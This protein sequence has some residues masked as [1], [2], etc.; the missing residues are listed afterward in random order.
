MI[1]VARDTVIVLFDMETA[2]TTS[3]TAANIFAQAIK[4]LAA[5][6][7]SLIVIFVSKGLLKIIAGVGAAMTT[8]AGGAVG[9]AGGVRIL[10]VAVRGLLGPFGLVLIAIEAVIFFWDDLVEALGF[11]TEAMEDATEAT[12]NLKAA[13]EGLANTEVTN[14][15]KLA[16]LQAEG[17]AVRE[18]IR[19]NQEQQEAIKKAQLK[20]GVAEGLTPIGQAF[21]ARVQEEE[22]ERLAAEAA[23]LGQE[24]TELQNR[25]EAAGRSTDLATKSFENMNTA[26]RKLGG[27]GEVERLRTAISSIVDTALPGAKAAR[28]FS[29]NLAELNN[30]LRIINENPDIPLSEFEAALGRTKAEI[31]EARDAMIALHEANKVTFAGSLEAIRLE[32]E[33]AKLSSDERRIAVALAKEEKRL[34]EALILLNAEEKQQLE[35]ALRL[36]EVTKKATTERENEQ[37]RIVRA[38]RSFIKGQKEQALG[39][40]KEALLINKTGREGEKLAAVFETIEKAT[41]AGFN[42]EQITKYADETKRAFEEMQALEQ[43]AR[44]GGFGDGIKD[45]F[46]EMSEDVKTFREL[47]KESALAM[48]GAFVNAFKEFAETGRI[49]L[50]TLV[51]D[52]NTALLDIF[53]EQAVNEVGAIFGGLFG[54]DEATTEQKFATAVET[55]REAVNKFAGGGG[56]GGSSGPNGREGVPTPGETPFEE[57]GFFDEFLTGLST[58][59]DDVI[60][61]FSADLPDIFTSAWDALSGIF[62]SESGGGI[63]GSLASLFGFGGPTLGSPNPQGG[64]GSGSLISTGLQLASLAFAKK[65][66]L[67]P[68]GLE[69]QS[70]ARGGRVAASD[71]DLSS[72]MDLGQG[73][74]PIIAHENESVIPA[75]E[76]RQLMAAGLMDRE[77]RLTFQ[78]FQ[79]GG[80]INAANPAEQAAPRDRGRARQASNPEFDMSEGPVSVVV[81]VNGATDADS[82]LSSGDQIAVELGAALQRVRARRG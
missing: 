4:L 27:E 25:I 81:E 24:F 21:T 13:Q 18:Q 47:V 39:F 58:T 71:L 77:G 6:V 60:N 73:A 57:P 8:A 69:I 78:A 28:E 17:D 12:N 22:L 44:E 59:F 5:A 54:D 15:S 31:I 68:S 16:A 65:G 30:A 62:G 32:T 43:L 1:D 40:A 55:F 50:D 74:V 53:A 42:E 61:F 29:E 2:L 11:G 36:L 26:I 72:L 76:V 38:Q 80:L 66:G 23:R 3:G 49:T 63:I 7:A 35:D 75:S 52:I 41:L 48:K 34:K 19:L 64:G 67:V 56:G 70:L 79:A 10:G 37:K 14:A 20:G 82:F 9:L 51:N 45:A 46:Q 33:A